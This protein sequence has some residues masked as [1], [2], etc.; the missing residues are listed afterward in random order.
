MGD[1]LP[2]MP[3]RQRRPIGVNSTRMEKAP[4]GALM[5]ICPIGARTSRRHDRLTMMTM[6]YEVKSWMRW[7]GWDEAA[8]VKRD[9][10]GRTIAH[11]GDKTF[12][13]NVEEAIAI[14]R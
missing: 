8:R 1:R 4:K 12:H 14:E 6:L 3:T 2:N 11:W 7:W 9:A 10:D 5:P 13:A